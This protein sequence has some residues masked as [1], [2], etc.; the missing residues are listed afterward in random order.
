MKE[1]GIDFIVDIYRVYIVHSSD[2]AHSFDDI[3]ILMPNIRAE[4]EKTICVY[5]LK[6]HC[7]ARVIDSTDY[8]DFKY[9]K[10]ENFLSSKELDLMKT[11][12]SPEFKENFIKDL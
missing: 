4:Y 5:D 10:D 7:E 1:K 12:L 2:G 3:Y 11:H 6:G 9:G 8:K